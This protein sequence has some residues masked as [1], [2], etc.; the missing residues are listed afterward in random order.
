MPKWGLTMREGKITK[1]LKKEGD[2]VQKDEELFEVET[3]K[4]TNV[5]EAPASGIL[6][7]IVAPA[8]LTVPVATV[9]A[10]I[11]GSEE[12]PDRLEMLQLP[13]EV[14]V[15]VSSTGDSFKAHAHEAR[16]KQSAHATPAA[17]RT[18]KELGIDLALV[19][20]SGPGGRIKAE[21]V[22]EFHEEGS[23]QPKVT[24]LAAEM[25]REAGLDLST[26]TGTGE[27]G[28]ITKEDVQRLLE[29]GPA[30]KEAELTRSI[31]F[32][33][34]RKTIAENTWASLKNT[35]QLTIFTEVDATEMVRFRDSVSEEHRDDKEVKVSYTD[36]IILATS[37]AL[38]GFPIMNSTLLGDEILLHDGVNMGIAVALTDGLIV[39]V[40]HDADK[41]ELLQI[42]R[43][44]RELIQKAREGTLTVH[45]VTGGTFT[46]TTLGTFGVDGFTPILMKYYLNISI[47]FR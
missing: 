20:G 30:E 4:V 40:L 19:S 8:G 13:K 46:I 38:K 11:A 17:R 7:Q 34:M 35:A 2:P 29:V 33:G 27:G 39:P 32:T 23:R 1:W 24:P 21:D 42:A 3:E 10:I 45:E 36:I 37:R 44:S 25:V 22:I 31:P 16:E 12:Q 15:S 43:E 14:T 28:K 47:Y 18:A 6:F 41:K 26:I 9:V 5:V